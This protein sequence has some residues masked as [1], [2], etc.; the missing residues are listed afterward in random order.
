MKKYRYKY[1]VEACQYK[2]GMESG[3]E[4]FFM[5]HFDTYSKKFKTQIEASDFI[6]NNN[7]I[8]EVSLD[9]SHFKIDYEAPIPYMLDC[10]SEIQYIHSITDYIVRFSNGRIKVLSKKEFEELFEET[11]EYEDF[12]RANKSKFKEFLSSK[13]SHKFC[14]LPNKKNPIPMPPVKE[15]KK[16]K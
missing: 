6:R 4:V 3:W 5:G 12:I 11:D 14:D 8:N 9:D 2:K 13:K 1:D 15:P 7:G 16:D 10:F